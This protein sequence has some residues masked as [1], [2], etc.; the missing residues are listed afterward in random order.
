MNDDVFLQ[1][2]GSEAY[3]LF[4]HFKSGY[5]NILNIKLASSKVQRNFCSTPRVGACFEAAHVN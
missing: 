1:A 3:N 5:F 4:E 2:L